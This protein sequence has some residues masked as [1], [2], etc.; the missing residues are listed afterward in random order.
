MKRL[1]IALE[2][3]KSE[4]REL[5]PILDA[6]ITDHFDDGFLHHRW[7]GDALRLSGPGAEGSI[8][9]ENGHLRLRAKL[10][11]PASWV[12]RTIRHKIQAALDDLAAKIG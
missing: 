9:H 4:M 8:V 5:R 11:P 1:D 2:T 10:R 7:E 12:H 6:A 3:G